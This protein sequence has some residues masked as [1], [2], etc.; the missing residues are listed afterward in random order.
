MFFSFQS[1]SIT[2]SLPLG[3]EGAE[4]RE[5]DEVPAPQRGVPLRPCRGGALLLPGIPHN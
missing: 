4:Q 1:I 5:A 3:G 2:P